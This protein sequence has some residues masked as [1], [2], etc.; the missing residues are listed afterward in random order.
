[1]LPWNE[2]RSDEDLM[3]QIED[4]GYYISDLV[5]DQIE[6]FWEEYEDPCEKCH[7]GDMTY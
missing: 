1:M 2:G 6:V 5:E 4:E 7:F 3:A